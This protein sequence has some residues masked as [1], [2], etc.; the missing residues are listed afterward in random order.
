M[1][2]DRI[3]SPFIFNPC[4]FQSFPNKESQRRVKFFYSVVLNSKRWWRGYFVN[5][6]HRHFRSRLHAIVLKH[7]W[8]QPF[9]VNTIWN[10]GETGDMYI[11]AVSS[12]RV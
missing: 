3:K 2:L 5:L 1:V 4:I 12:Y 11:Q 7:V 8:D 9:T 6:D 10:I